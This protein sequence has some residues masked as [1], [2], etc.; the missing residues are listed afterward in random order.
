MPDSRS[1]RSSLPSM[2]RFATT[3]LT[4]LSETCW[5]EFF[6]WPT[7]REVLSIFQTFYPVGV[8]FAQTVVHLPTCKGC[9]G[10]GVGQLLG[11]GMSPH[12]VI[13]WWKN[14]ETSSKTI[15]ALKI[16]RISSILVLIKFDGARPIWASLFKIERQLYCCLDPWNTSRN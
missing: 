1:S 12:R 2:H 11:V 8:H 7:S 6:F 5:N 10:G 14:P 15:M 4:L 3:L 16:T 9:L 13:G